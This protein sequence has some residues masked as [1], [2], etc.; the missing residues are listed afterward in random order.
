MKWILTILGALLLLAGTV[1]ILQGT[2]VYPVGFM[3]RQI[4]YAY[5]GIVVDVIAIG[6][7]IFANRRRKKLPPSS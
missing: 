6:V 1:W 4:K 5:Y 3:A 7:I 2:G